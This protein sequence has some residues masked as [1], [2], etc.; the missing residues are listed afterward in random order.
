MEGL[1]GGPK[2][3]GRPPSKCKAETSIV[4]TAVGGGHKKGLNIN[5]RARLGGAFLPY[6]P[7]GSGAGAKGG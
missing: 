5:S 3:G 6:D 4:P 7:T 2:Q 1:F